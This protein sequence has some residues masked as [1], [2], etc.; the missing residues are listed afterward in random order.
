MEENRGVVL[1]YST[2]AVFRLEKALK[3]AGITVKLIPT[4]RNLSSD[5]G[6]ALLFPWER[7]PTVKSLIEKLDLEIE[8]LHPL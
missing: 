7:L 1:F 2:H 8:A 4:P 3:N 6:T 5:C